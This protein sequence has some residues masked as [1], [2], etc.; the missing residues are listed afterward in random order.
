MSLA[1]SDNFEEC[2][3]LLLSLGRHSAYLADLWSLTHHI[4]EISLLLSE[5]FP[6]TPSSCFYD[7]TVSDA[8]L[9]KVEVPSFCLP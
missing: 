9:L 6:L 7:L 2:S 1:Y 5:Q 3:A 8:S 4:A